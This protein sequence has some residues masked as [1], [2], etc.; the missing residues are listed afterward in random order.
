MSFA[1]DPGG[2]LMTLG[3]LWNGYLRVGLWKDRKQKSYKVHRLVLLAFSGPSD[4]E[5]NHLNGIKT[6]NRLENLEYCTPSEN[7]KH[8]FSLGLQ[9]PRHG[10]KNPSAKLTEEKIKLI[11]ESTDTH[12]KI[13]TRFG[14]SRALIGQIKQRKIWTH[15]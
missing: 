14:V 8:A 12:Q 4:L 9:Q 15:V 13:A 1:N 6:D 5:C 11:L 10:S 3:L 7:Q 2:K